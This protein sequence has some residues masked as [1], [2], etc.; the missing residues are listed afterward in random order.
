MKLWYDYTVY[1][2]LW[3]LQQT[4]TVFSQFWVTVYIWNCFSLLYCIFTTLP[5]T[6]HSDHLTTWSLHLILFDLPFLPLPAVYWG[7]RKLNI[8]NFANVCFADVSTGKTIRSFLK[9]SLTLNW[10]DLR[11]VFC[12]FSSNY[13]FSSPTGSWTSGV[14]SHQDENGWTV[15]GEI[16]VQSLLQQ[17]R[18]YKHW[19]L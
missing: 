3:V 10:A 8:L 12:S 18:N 6:S 13:H 4:G 15:H 5:H 7:W 17:V 14:H 19:T 2:Q 9:L 16:Q 11:A 1:D